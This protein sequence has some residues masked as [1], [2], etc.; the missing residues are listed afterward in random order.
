MELNKEN[1]A[2]LFQT[3]KNQKQDLGNIINPILPNCNSE[4]ERLELCHVGKMLWILDEEISIVKK[5]ESPDFIIEKNGHRIG[6][7]HLVL[8]N[9]TNVKIEG[10]KRNLVAQA[11]TIY[12]KKYSE[13]KPYFGQYPDC[14]FLLVG[15]DFSKKF[16]FGKSDLSIL[17]EKIATYVW[18]IANNLNVD[19]PDFISYTHLG[20]H[21]QNNFYYKSDINQ[22]SNLELHRIVEAIL[23]KEKLIT[24]YK[25]NSNANEQWLLLTAGG[26]SADS[27]E[28]DEFQISSFNS[29]FDRI[30]LLDDF[31]ARLFRIK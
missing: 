28:I 25:V 8:K 2:M 9:E 29:S 13:F 5:F 26:L 11:Q 18:S 17:A 22:T 19:R 27:F 30:Y 1:I 7:E 12:N 20:P 15:I 24:S 23:K 14:P 4:K 31:N 16:N 10:S 3:M 21:T 6:L